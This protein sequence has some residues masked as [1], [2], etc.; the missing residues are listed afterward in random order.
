MVRNFRAS[1]ATLSQIL[2]NS[3]ATLAI[4]LAGNPLVP[5]LLV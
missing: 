3:L 1:R 5:S 2:A 4:A